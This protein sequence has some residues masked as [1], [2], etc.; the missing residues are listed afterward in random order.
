MLC[1]L[2]CCYTTK[3]IPKTKTKA[4]LTYKTILTYTI[5]VLLFSCVS[6]PVLNSM[7]TK[8]ETEKNSSEAKQ[9]ISCPIVE[10]E[11]MRKNGQLSGYTEYYLERSI[12]DYFIKFCESSVSKEELE[13]AL[14]KQD[15]MIKT[16]KLEIELREGE[17]DICPD[18]PAEMQSR[19]GEYAVIYR[20]IE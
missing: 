15:G 17:W 7:D 12:Q 11:F 20:I 19:I 3:K 9:I 16:L 13:L 4:M 5:T 2:T 8:N 10:K 14:E 18:D 6:K 1:F